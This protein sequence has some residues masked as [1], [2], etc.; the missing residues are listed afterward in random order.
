MTS[1]E[2]VTS[3]MVKIVQAKSCYDKNMMGDVLKHLIPAVE[4]IADVLLDELARA[5]PA[6]D[7]GEAGA[8]E[9][10]DGK[11][12][13]V[14]HFAREQHWTWHSTEAAARAEAERLA[15]G[16]REAR[17]VRWV[18]TCKAAAAWE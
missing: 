3:A 6:P 11:G 14:F 13:G 9:G 5:A 1:K 12:W 17:L 7:T 16:D 4:A 8:G 18:G 15:K 2:R 10:D